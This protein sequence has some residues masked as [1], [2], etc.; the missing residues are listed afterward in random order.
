MSATLLKASFF[1]HK[2]HVWQGLMAVLGIAIGVSVV[3][4]IDLAN[5]SAKVAFRQSMK[6]VMG[7]ATHSIIGVE[8]SVP[9]SLYTRLRLNKIRA[10]APVVE[11]NVTLRGKVSQTFTLL[12]VDPFAEQ[13]FRPTSQ[14]ITY[15]HP[16][17]FPDF[18]T[19]PSGVVLSERSANDLGIAIGDTLSLQ[20]GSLISTV[21]LIGVIESKNR[22]EDHSLENLVLT[23]ISTAQGLLNRPGR[24]SR[25]DL[26]IEDSPTGKS[27]K[28][29]VS[30]MLSPDLKLQ[31]AQSRQAMADQMTR[32]FEL[33]LSALSWLALIVGMFLIY[34]MMTFS[35][36]Q[37]QQFFGLLRT[38]GVL[39]AEIFRLILLEAFAFG[40]IGSLSGIFIGLMLADGMVDLVSR[41][42]NDLYYTTKVQSVVI[43][44]LSL[45]KGLLLGTLFTILSALKPARE[46]MAQPPALMLK[47]SRSENRMNKLIPTLSL[48]GAFLIASSFFVFQF[49]GAFILL[50]YGGILLLILGASLLTP[51]MVRILLLLITPILS[52]FW[53][54]SATLAMN[55]IQAQLS[56]SSVA[57]AS[58]G[59]AVSAT[60]AVGT[61]IGSFRGTVVSWLEERLKADIYISAPS[62]VSRR[63]D[64]TLPF[65]LVSRYDS[66]PEISQ[67][68]FYREIQV[69]LKNNLINVIG[70]N[71]TEEIKTMYR[72]KSGDEEQLWAK[73]ESNQGILITEPFSFNYELAVGDTLRLPTINGEKAFHVEGV[74]Y[75]YGSD[76]GYIT[77][78]Y[79]QFLTHWP[80]TSI[81]AISIL[82]KDD[83][84]L[85]ALT[86]RIRNLS[87][88]NEQL[89]V[90]TNRYV[91]AAS[92]DIFDRSF[93]IANVLQLLTIIVA[94][95]GIF[96]ALMA[97]Q[98]EKSREIG[99]LRATGLT[100]K[101]LWEITLL[102]TSVMGFMAGILALP[103][104]N[105]LAWVLIHVISARSFG[106]TFQFELFPNLYLQAIV[107]AIG[108]ALISGLYPAYRMAK[109]LPALALREE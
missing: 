71:L 14:K 109:T 87:P 80:D 62:L 98:L 100:T 84:N 90:T 99:I 48:A 105:L 79:Q 51:L 8:S 89:M 104:G 19:H 15:E 17:S 13:Q 53:G 33:N 67:V 72:F 36:V 30:E 6:S 76:L 55:N 65:E 59:M 102:Q 21:T 25:I 73:L 45:S 20:Y 40:A 108:S 3:I 5:E 97:F 4:S 66:I 83:T 31:P 47:R 24:L 50:N 74:Y 58:L 44:G 28:K 52:V 46:A 11:G 29:A 7:N 26:I 43:S 12:G 49:S 94:L 96:S 61:M 63:N 56:R 91:R 16:Y 92:I 37:R 81:S 85:D 57:I 69:P 9:D 38:T 77:L 34:N 93:A 35:V 68:S 60:F 18:I 10:S 54:T 82:A 2:K 107:L 103:L 1:Y 32:A 64:A 86:K 23:D 95:I 27:L 78:P 39:K 88:P 106:W 41:S 22:S 75:D 42:I 101:E 70:I